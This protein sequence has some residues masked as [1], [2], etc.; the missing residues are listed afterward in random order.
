MY[1]RILLPNVTIV[2]LFM[3]LYNLKY[4][5]YF[6]TYVHFWHIHLAFITLDIS[7]S[8]RSL[9]PVSSLHSISN[10][11]GVVLSR[12]G[13]KQLLAC[14]SH[15]QPHNQHALN[16]VKLVMGLATMHY[17]PPSKTILH[18]VWG[19]VSRLERTPSTFMAGRKPLTN[20]K[21]VVKSDIVPNHHIIW[22][23]RPHHSHS[24]EWAHCK[25]PP[26]NKQDILCCRV[27][28]WEHG[29]IHHCQSSQ[30]TLLC[31]P[32]TGRPHPLSLHGLCCSCHVF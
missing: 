8:V 26:S 11:P 30:D 27:Q 14:H 23:V 13:G 32:L 19:R 17:P 10:T 3:Q 12:P 25:G 21:G 28:R 16:P 4:F 24:Q 9:L 15:P 18:W 5:D 29:E 6:D 1:F 20:K 31:Y 7:L 22:Y 2:W